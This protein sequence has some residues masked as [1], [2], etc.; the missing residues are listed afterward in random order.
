ME[1]INLIIL[2]AAILLLVSIFTSLISF[3]IGA[4]LLLIFLGVGLAAGE[5]GIGGIAFDNTP[6]AFLIG[7]VALAIILF[8]S[9][10]DTRFSSYRAAAWP[11]LTVATL[12]VVIT[13]SLV[14]VAA[15]YALGLS[16]LEAL[17]VGAI[18]S[19]TDAAAVFFLLRVGGITLRDRVRST[20]EIESGTNDPMSIFLTI[21]LVELIAS[22]G[23]GSPWHLALLFI[24]QIGG[25]LL[26][27]VAGGGI[28]ILTINR[29]RLEP[30]L[31]PVV[32]IS[33][34]LFIFALAATLGGSGFLAVYVAGLIA[35]NAKLRGGQSLRR[36]HTGITWL[37][38]IVMFVMLGLLATPSRFLDLFV[39]AALLALVLIL[40][41]RPLAIW[42]CLAPFRFTANE[43]TFIAWVG[44]RGAVSILLAI[45]PTLFDLPNGQLYFNIAFL[46]VLMSLLV[47]GWTIRPLAHWL[48]LIVPPRIGPVDRVELELPGQADYELVA[49]TIREHSPVVSGHRL[50]RWA[51]PSLIIRDGH[52][53]T[54]HSVRQLQAGDLV[55]LFT[56]PSRVALLDRL[57]GETRELVEDDRQ[58]FGDLTLKAD[59]TVGALAELYGLP[60]SVRNARLTLADLFRQEFRDAVEVGDRLRM[61]AVELIARDMEDGEL[62]TVGLA[63]EPATPAAG[64]RIPV[65]PRPSDLIQAIK[66]SRSRFQFRLW[67]RRQRRADRIARRQL[68][69]DA[70]K[71]E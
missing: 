34:A 18:V 64:F 36:F 17:L 66:A 15:R 46:I 35:G 38:Q 22:G 11:A 43:T 4:P 6:A 8:D 58:F 28:L 30:G 32:S 5:E 31:Y 62:L 71:R 45:V 42:L 3:R 20:L 13:T 14:G 54:V 19:S 16:W 69:A 65:I 40:V 37:S 25:G 70:K 23:T 56:A 29:I 60:L 7:S 44:L 52:V 59:I 50:P 48:K 67:Q 12:G 2:V 21:S 51:R 49:Y 63:L 26:F 41:A 68:E 39:P 9:G 1:L 24:W 33:L 57:F 55:Y 10:F 53:Q 47:Q 27:G 61:G